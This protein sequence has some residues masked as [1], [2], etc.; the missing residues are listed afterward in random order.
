[1]ATAGF[2]V[3]DDIKSKADELADQFAKNGGG[4]KSDFFRALLETYQMQMAAGAM[5]GRSD[6][7]A[8][9]NELLGQFKTVY[10]ASLTLAQNAADVARKEQAATIERNE[11]TISDLQEKSL[12][13]K[14]AAD[15]AHT[16]RDAARTE[17]KERTAELDSIKK[18]LEA[19]QAASEKNAATAAETIEQTKRF[20][21]TLQAQMD[22]MRK[23]VEK[24]A[25]E[26]E[27]AAALEAES[28]KLKAD[29]HAAIE[30]AEKAEAEAAGLSKKLAE[31]TEKAKTDATELK[32]RYDEKFDNL[33]EKLTNEKEAAVLEERRFVDS[34]LRAAVDAADVKHQERIDKMQA[35]IDK[36]TEQR[37]AWQE[38]FY[39]LREE[40]K[41][42]EQAETPEG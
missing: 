17:L 4:N 10:L 15:A 3:T 28:E 8:H 19:T 1:M 2:N 39:A 14:E 25:T 18:E 31:Q 35:A 22:E 9:V 24:A 13:L 36:L 37:D 40:Q 34:Q 42:S 7:I 27:A 32:G 33:R 11:K 5:P 29:L 16:E 23:K 20:N 41:G 26:L 21:E 30:R 38:K 12:K 6:E